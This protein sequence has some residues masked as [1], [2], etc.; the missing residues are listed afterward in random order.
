LPHTID[1]ISAGEVALVFFF[2]H[3][4][5]HH[6]RHVNMS[7]ENPLLSD[8]VFPRFDAVQ[9]VHVVPGIRHVLAESE[10]ELEE[11]EKGLQGLG[12]GVTVSFLLPALERLTDRIGKTWGIC[13]HLKGVKDS[14]P[15]RK[16]VEEVQ[17]EKVAFFLKLAQ[18]EHIFKAYKNIRN[19]TAWPTLSEAQQRI[20]EAGIREAELA[21]VAL[22]GANKDRFNEIQKRLAQLSTDF[23]NNVLDATKSFSVRLTTKEEVD[24][25][26]ESA[27]ALAAQTAK[28]KGDEGA[29]P[30]AGPWVITLDL[31]SYM[32]V[33]QYAK[34]RSLREK[35]YK[36]YITRASELGQYEGKSIDNTPL[37]KEILQ[38]R[39]EKAG[40]LGKKHY[41][42]S[43]LLE[44][45]RVGNSI[46]EQLSSTS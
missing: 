18:S 11:L 30:E 26:P 22:T 41:A 2:T 44:S 33:M 36:A 23:S 4:V 13:T 27:L 3:L 1:I 24:G 39:K 31:P 45:V 38:L 21:G 42:V 32:P 19:S 14:E 35:L 46:F 28:S 8:A 12:E 6:H 9:A 10:R 43:F 37:I 29:T 20:I 16:A 25:L 40:L 5:K 15:L 7:D 34:D 17:P